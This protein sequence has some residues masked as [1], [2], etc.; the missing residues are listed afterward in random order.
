MKPRHVP[1]RTCV[2]CK[3]KRPKRDLLRVVRTTDGE[4]V[5][6]ATGKVN[7]RG[8]YVCVAEDGGEDQSGDNRGGH[9]GERQ[10]RARL[11]QALK[12]DL[13]QDDIDRLSEAARAV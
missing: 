1:M 7:G 5:V 11:G 8:G 10:I 4:V 12:V 6:D 13:A 9:W 2:V 3:E